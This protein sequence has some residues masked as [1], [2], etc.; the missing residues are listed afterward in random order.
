[1][2]RL[3]F[4]TRLW[5]RAIENAGVAKIAAWVDAGAPEGDSKDKPAPVEWMDGWNINPDMVFTMPSGF[6]KDTWVE[7]AEIRPGNR[8][9][10]HH[11]SVCVRPPGSISG[12]PDPEAPPPP[13]GPS[14]DEWFVGSLPGIQPQG[15]FA[16]EMH[17]PP[18]YRLLSL[19]V[20]EF[21]F[22]IPPGDPNYEAHANAAFNQPVRVIYPQPHMHLPGKD[23]EIKFV[24]PGKVMA[25]SRTARAN[26]AP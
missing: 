21:N 11:V 19:G 15:Y 13:S 14:Q 24:N 6:T 4:G 10:V 16:P 1:M 22:A 20:A 7:D 9:V 5:A 18:K 17:S 12:P 8:A 3:F 26:A 25:S 2:R 23:T